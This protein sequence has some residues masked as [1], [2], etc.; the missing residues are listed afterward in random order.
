MHLPAITFVLSAGQLWV[1]WTHHLSCFLLHFWM[2]TTGPVEILLQRWLLR[3]KS[4][5][6]DICFTFVAK[7]RQLK[8]PI[9][10]YISFNTNIIEP[11]PRSWKDQRKMRHHLAWKNSTNI[12]HFRLI[13]DVHCPV[14][15]PESRS[16]S[17]LPGGRHTPSTLNRKPKTDQRISFRFCIFFFF[18]NMTC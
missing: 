11:Q 18:R 3:K 15:W 10:C 17:L 1:W 7:L 14:C 4:P 6:Y 16:G 13:A 5:Q 8:Y 2:A 9:A 12:R